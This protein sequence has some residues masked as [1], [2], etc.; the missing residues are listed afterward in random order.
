MAI[1]GF[2][3]HTL[4]DQVHNV[5]RALDAMPELST[6]GI[7]KD[8]YVVAVADAPAAKMEAVVD[9]VKTVAGVIAVYVTSYTTEDEDEQINGED[10]FGHKAPS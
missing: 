1:L 8:A 9:R 5:E 3:T 4:T 10:V 6:Y 2:L 7:H